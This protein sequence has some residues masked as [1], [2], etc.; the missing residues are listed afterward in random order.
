MTADDPRD[1][2]YVP[3]RPTGDGA[4]RARYWRVAMGLQAVDGLEPS[5]YLR[6]L[7]EGNVAGELTLE[8]TGDL[9][10]A[11]HRPDDARGSSADEDHRE[12][13]LVSQRIAELLER[14]AFALVPSMLSAVHGAL[15]Q[16]LDPA[17]Y[18]PGMYKEVAL[19]KQ[20]AI[21]NGDSVLYADPS[22]VERSLAYLIE[23]EGRRAYGC[24][25]RGADLEA[26]ARLIAR[27]WQV[28]PFVEGNTR[29]VAV[30]S[31]LYL[32][33]LGFSVGNDPFERHARYFRD[34]LVRANYRN[35]PA[36][37]LPDLAPLT[38]F[39][40]SLLNGAPADFSSDAL[41]CQPLFD[42]PSLLRNVDPA[43]AIEA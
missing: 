15:F 12:A 31:E 11:Y 6:T 23:E 21:L 8:E 19:V 42:D 32:A 7:A 9:I 3:A 26:F 37:V 41:R 4:V 20:E 5:P 38:G 30:F 24:E 17:V 40:D 18:H 2:D 22:L 1:Y 36:G 34:A 16:D 10:R 25:L 14:N 28:H 13:D 43:L 39:Y 29:T 33:H 27:L 35:A